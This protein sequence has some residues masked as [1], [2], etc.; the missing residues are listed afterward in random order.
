[1]RS[2]TDNLLLFLIAILFFFSSRV[3]FG[4]DYFVVED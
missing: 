2:E 4:V 3:N 1:M